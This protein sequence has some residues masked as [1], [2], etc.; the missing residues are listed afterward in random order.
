MESSEAR[1]VK[2]IKLTYR[3]ELFCT[4][5]HTVFVGTYVAASNQSET[6][7]YSLQCDHDN[8]MRDMHKIK[9]ILKTVTY[10]QKSKYLFCNINWRPVKFLISKTYKSLTIAHKNQWFLKKRISKTIIV[11]NESRWSWVTSDKICC[12]CVTE[13]FYLFQNDLINS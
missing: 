2:L 5:R 7:W 8:R 10:V 9:S 1:K 6:F 11:R 13:F 12:S 4:T 3:R